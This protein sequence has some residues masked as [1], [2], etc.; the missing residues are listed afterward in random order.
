MRQIH[1]V[2]QSHCERS[3]RTAEIVSTL[4]CHLQGTQTYNGHRRGHRL[5][6]AG[7]SGRNGIVTFS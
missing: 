5:C 6:L 4:R 3:G 7:P 1:P 2:F